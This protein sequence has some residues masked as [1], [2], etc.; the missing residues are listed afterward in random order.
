MGKWLYVLALLAA[1]ATA[2]I[3]V[4]DFSQREVVLEQPAQRIIALAPH[5]VENLFSA[6]A[7]DKVVGVVSYSDFP[8]AALDIPEV[9]SYKAF[10][11]EKII[12]L[13]PD[14]IVMWASGN[15]MARLEEL[16]IL[17]IP[18]YVS[19][20]RKLADIGRSIR[21]Y[22]KLTGADPQRTS[23]ADRVDRTI[24]QL[25]QQYSNEK[26]L[27]VFYQVWNEPLQTLNQDHL[28]S[29]VISLCGGKNV[30][31]DAQSLAPKISLEAVLKRDPDLIVASGMDIARP[32]WLDSWLDYPFLT[33]VKD[34]ALF[35]VPPDH[36]QR[37]TARILLG[38]ARLCEQ[39]DSRRSP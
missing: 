25:R 20:P 35:F 37:P 34:E 33:A 1:Q 7:G 32:E 11:L 29:R 2:E 38:A 39:I 30:F 22:E 16:A 23:E 27:S 3:R 9:G 15:G 31:A 8:R 18:I 6:G 12:S 10:S 17:N 24:A 13:E 4:F 21:D 28:I 36:I 5:V 26:Q 14:L 19:E